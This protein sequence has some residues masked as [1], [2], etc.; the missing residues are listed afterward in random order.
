MAAEEVPQNI[1]CETFDKI[2]EV[3]EKR[4][5]TTDS[6]IEILHG[7]QE[8]LGYLPPPVQIY[9]AEK[10]DMP[11]G[12]VEGVVS[13]YSFFTTVPRGR[14]TVKVCQGTACYVRGGKRVLESV[15]KQCGCKV[16]ETDDEMRFSVDVVRCVGA[17]GLAPVITVDDDV[18][19]RMKPTKVADVL[20]KYD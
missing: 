19:D 17:C 2:D 5:S 18:Y 15:I 20:S 14:H 1:C 9:I 16:G 13:F 3:I 8:E 7:V 12:A 4:G 10:L 11:V 6:L